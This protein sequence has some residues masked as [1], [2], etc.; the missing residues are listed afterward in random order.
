MSANAACMS[1]F[2]KRWS[3]LKMAGI[4]VRLDSRNM[5]QRLVESATLRTLEDRLSNRGKQ[6]TSATV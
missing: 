2:Q 1:M 5:E 4:Y 3:V 6:R